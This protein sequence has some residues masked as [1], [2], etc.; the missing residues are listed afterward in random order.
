MPD[1]NYRNE[2]VKALYDYMDIPVIPDDEDA[3]IPDYPYITYSIT[4]P[5]SKTGQDSITYEQ[6]EEGANR[7]YDNLNE[8]SFSFTCY[9][10]KRDEAQMLCLRLEEY[11]GRIGRDN[12]SEAN[13]VVVEV[14]SAQNRSTLLVDH[15]VRR[16]GLDVRF[17]INDRSVENIGAI[18]LIEIKNTGG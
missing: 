8:P 17:R 18:E 13:I 15:Y 11:F 9:S 1:L 3:E 7:V 14:S 10:D 5:F 4:T 16:W 12:L 2:I 6:T